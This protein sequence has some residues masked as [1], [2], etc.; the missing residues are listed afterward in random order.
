M[1]NLNGHSLEDEIDQMF[2][3]LSSGISERPFD[4][5]IEGIQIR[6]SHPMALWFP[7]GYDREVYQDNREAIILDVRRGRKKTGNG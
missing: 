4:L 1:K 2:T 6:K 7:Y 5:E 3:G